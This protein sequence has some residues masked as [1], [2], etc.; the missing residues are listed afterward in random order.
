M[1]QQE[2]SAPPATASSVIRIVGPLEDDL[3]ASILW[4]RATEGEV[5]EAVTWF[6][7]DDGLCS[8]LRRTRIGRVALATGGGVVATGLSTDATLSGF[9]PVVVQAVST[10]DAAASESP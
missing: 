5:L 10:A 2:K 4:T 6:T 8:E 1:A 3:I 7:A 9:P